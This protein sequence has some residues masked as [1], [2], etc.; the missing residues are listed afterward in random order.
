MT[1]TDE[2]SKTIAELIEQGITPYPYRYDKSHFIQQVLAEFAEDETRT[3]QVAIAGRIMLFRKMGRATFMHI[4][5][6]TGRMQLYFKLDNLGQDAYRLLK[7]LDVGDIIGARGE[8]FRTRTGEITLLVSAYELLSKAIRPLPEKYHGLRDKA[9]IY[10]QRALDMIMNPESL[11]T[12]TTRARIM[13]HI[14][15]WFYKR[16]FMEVDVPAIQLTYGG[17][18]AKP[19][20]TYINA[21][22]EHAFLSISP[23]LYLKRYIVG[24]MERV[25]SL[26]KAFRNE[27]L[28]ATHHPE[29]TLME[30]YQA[31]VDY[32]D[33]ME[34][35]E[36]L[37]AD[38]VQAITGSKVLR[39]QGQDI[40]FATP[41]AR[42]PLISL[43]AREVGRDPY[44]MSLADLWER[45][46]QVEGKD[47]P[48]K[49]AGHGELIMFLFDALC[50]HKLLQPTF[51]TDY[52][53]ESSPL[54]KQHREDPRLIERFELF[55]AGKEFANAYSEQNNPLKQR[56]AL[57]AQAKRLRA[58]AEEAM[59]MDEWFVRAVEYGMPPTGGMGCGVDR[60]VM[61]LTG[62]ESIKD[63]I[64]FPLVSQDKAEAGKKETAQGP[65]TAGITMDQA[66]ALFEQYV[67]S[68]RLRL[69]SLESA[70]VMK[71]LARHFGLN[72]DVWYIAG[73]LH[74]LD[75]DK[76]QAPDKHGLLTVEV[77]TQKG[78]HPH[79]VQAIKRH[80]EG[81]GEPRQTFMDH[82]LAAAESITG[83]IYA[84]ALVY[85][86]K[87][88]ADVKVKSILKRMKKKD[89]ARKVSRE[90][91]QE[92]EHL[93][94][95]LEE[96]AAIALA[97]MAEIAD[98]IGL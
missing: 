30:C 56:D 36:N 5:D 58:G 14:R 61:L 89:F 83:L 77:L 19:F 22:N 28:D 92:C 45:C 59:P 55:I 43:V 9:L 86:S 12:F 82:A 8:I 72:E 35:T 27:G 62:R 37:Y 17:A 78:V 1:Y 52:P 94:L 68:D 70:Q 64:A 16:G 20:T 87:K 39:Y 75:F 41:F 51:V 93:G 57:E 95:A 38:M 73:L 67:T 84:T 15:E 85:P 66:Q 63:V 48:A 24:G 21:T 2:R 79:I 74:D 29:F 88:I 18:E 76:E 6:M 34:L 13:R 65:D 81:L 31:Y 3:L 90:A 32:S 71:H 60:L 26:G 23:E 98:T 46:R 11:Q 7:K 80:N 96:F 25:F 54:C 50:E 69:H 44:A 91:I 33:M 40:S 47:L 10:R 42:R 53:K 49:D 97:G 4:Q